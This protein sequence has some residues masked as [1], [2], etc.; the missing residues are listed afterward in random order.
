M[1]LTKR[2]LTVILS[3]LLILPVF[4]VSANTDY[5][6]KHTDHTD[7]ALEAVAEGM[8]LLKNKNSALPLKSGANIA[9]FGD[10]QLFVSSTEIGYQIGGGGSGWVSSVFGTPSGPADA[11][12]EEE[13]Q[14]KVN[15]YKPL[16]EQYKNDISYIPDA[17][18]YDSAAA[19]ADTAVMFIT[20]FSSEN[21]DISVNDW[22][23]I[24]L[25]EILPYLFVKG[26]S[27]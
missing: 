16:L 6:Y 15:I 22:Y 12:L 4:V 2:I 5:G 7:L 20:R 26:S 10:G 25:V 3:M 23:L 24:G 21:A 19:F 9:L 13:E 18:M 27:T 14:G 17:A 8:V 11:L 1:K